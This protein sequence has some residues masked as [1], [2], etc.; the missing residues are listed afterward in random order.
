MLRKSYEAIYLGLHTRASNPALLRRYPQALWKLGGEKDICAEVK[1][2]LIYHFCLKVVSLWKIV[3]CVS[4]KQ[5][6]NSLNTQKH[7]FSV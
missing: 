7:Y 6:Q 1:F 2:F 4:S 5:K 3:A